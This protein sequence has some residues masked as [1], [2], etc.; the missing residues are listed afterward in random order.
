MTSVLLFGLL[1]GMRHTFEADH[2]AAM[3]SLSARTV[4]LKHAAFQGVIWGVGH[5]LTLL[6]F[7]LLVITLNIQLSEQYSLWLEII[8]GVMLIFLGIAVFKDIVK[9]K[10]H[11]HTHKHNDG[12]V[13]IH[14]HSHKNVP[15]EN[16]THQHK[17]NFPYRALYVG[18]VHGL[19]GTSALVVLVLAS[20]DSKIMSF[21]YISIF[22]VGSIIGMGLL[23]LTIAIPLH[24]AV[25]KFRRLH[26]SLLSLAG[27]SAILT[28]SFLIYHIGVNKGLLVALV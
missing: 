10:L 27:V 21:L 19:A 17:N 11:F 25:N 1:M 18:I 24:H 20:V 14:V 15:L 8:V 28:G 22:G 2:I 26:I 9:K 5:T 3:A 23:T 12:T 16:H 7:G 6:F 4:S 13:H